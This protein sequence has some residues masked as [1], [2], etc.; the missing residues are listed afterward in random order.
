MIADGRKA[1]L[2]GVLAGD[3][4]GTLFL[5]MDLQIQG[6]KRWLANTR[7]K[8]SVVVDAGAARAL[9]QGGKS[10]LASGIVR[11]EG[12]FDQEELIAVTDEQG[13][14]I[15]RGLVRYSAAEVDRI[16]GKRS[17]EIEGILGEKNTDAVIHRD[18]MVVL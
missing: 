16:R 6:R 13:S 18:D 7:K 8:G 2:R 3:E 9:T 10:L 12:D 11:V 5:P 1:S 4:V 17:D 15:A 14:E